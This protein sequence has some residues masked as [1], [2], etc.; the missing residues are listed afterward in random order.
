MGNRDPSS[1]KNV[2]QATNRQMRCPADPLND[3][4]P[5]GIK[6]TPTV[7]AHLARRHAPGPPETLV[8]LHHRGYRNPK[9]RRHRPAGL[10]RLNSRHNT[11][12][13]IKRIRSGHGCW[14]PSPAHTLNQKSDQMGIPFRFRQIMTRSRRAK[15]ALR[16]CWRSWTGLAIFPISIRC[17]FR[18]CPGSSVGRAHD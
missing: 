16:P 2:P 5:M 15:A 18:R 3:E 9:T 7:A 8:P 4:V 10:T 1:H 13:K 12:A 11:L 17:R 6:Y 14:P